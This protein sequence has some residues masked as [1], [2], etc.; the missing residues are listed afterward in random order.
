MTDLLDACAARPIPAAE[1]I[2]ADPSL[3]SLR[4]VNDPL[5]LATALTLAKAIS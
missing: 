1:L 5:S 3:H 4:N 2:D